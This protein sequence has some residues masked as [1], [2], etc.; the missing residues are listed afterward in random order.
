ME[1]SKVINNDNINNTD[2]SL[3]QSTGMLTPILLILGD[4]TVTPPVEEEP[5]LLEE[6]EETKYKA[7]INSEYESK[8]PTITFESNASSQCDVNYV[9]AVTELDK[10]MPVS[11]DSQNYNN[12]I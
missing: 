12:N 6:D 1:E 7:V 10:N 9:I 4:G 3:L 5:V 11:Y 8:I 2:M